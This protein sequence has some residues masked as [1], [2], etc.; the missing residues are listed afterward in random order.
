MRIS[1][2]FAKL[3]TPNV[4]TI[5]HLTDMFPVA[6]EKNKMRGSYFLL[7]DYL[8]FDLIGITDNKIKFNLPQIKCIMQQLLNGLVYLHE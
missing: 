2:L 4:S 8:N 5:N 7:F 6:S 3:S 1:S